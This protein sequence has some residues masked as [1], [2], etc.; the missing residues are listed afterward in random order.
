MTTANNRISLDDLV[1]CPSC[2]AL[3]YRLS[4]DSG[5]VARCERCGLVIQS[6]KPHSVDRSLAAVIAVFVL[7]LLAL[8]LPLLGLSRAG[9]ESRISILEATL[10]LWRQGF[11]WLSISA[12][13]FLIGLPLVRCLLLAFP[14]ATIRIGA[15]VGSAQRLA[16]RW[17]MRLGP[18]AM[19]EIFLVGVAV[20]LVKISTLARLEIG[21]AFW[22][23]LS[24]ILASLLLELALCRDSIW[25][26]LA[27]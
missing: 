3:H 14:L 17:A 20:S 19:S 23:L 12:A 27:P 15:R 10:G 9:I 5:E 22:A 4:L 6:H 26:A 1:A 8:S 13:V 16:F 7:L 11:T 25:R 18:W 2:D 24:A 21:L